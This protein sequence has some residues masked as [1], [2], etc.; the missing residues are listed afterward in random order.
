[1]NW[2]R[3]LI[4]KSSRKLSQETALPQ[5][6][7]SGA[8]A[9][10]VPR[11]RFV[12]SSGQAVEE[13]AKSCVG[14]DGV[15]RPVLEAP[16]DD[17][18]PEAWV[19]A[20]CRTSDKS[21]A[22]AWTARVGDESALADIAAR[23]RF[24]EVRLAA[25]SRIA[26]PV[27]FARVAEASRDKDKRIFRLCSERLR[28]QRDAAQRRERCERLGQELRE[29]LATVPIPGTRLPPLEQEF[30]ALE[31]VSASSEILVWLDQVRERFRAETRA[32]HQMQADLAAG[33][34]ILAEIQST[35]APSPKKREAWADRLREME[36]IAAE[37]PAWLLAHQDGRR[38]R[39]VLGQVES[40]LAH[41]AADSRDASAEQLSSGGILDVAGVHTVLEIA[42]VMPASPIDGEVMAGQDEL[43]RARSE[44][45]GTASPSRRGREQVNAKQADSPSDSEP[46]AQLSLQKDE[47]ATL[48]TLLTEVEGFL[49]KGQLA[50][51]E[52]VDKR[53]EQVAQGA[54]P[55]GAVGR[56]WSRARGQIARLRSWA[57]WGTDQ[58]REHLIAD[59]ESLLRGEP[60]LDER[61]RLVPAWRR[62]WKRLNTH[63][64]ATKEQWERFN[65]ALTL[66]YEPVAAKRAEEIA[67][68]KL[69]RARKVQLCD[70]LEPWLAQVD[71][72][73]LDCR[74]IEAKRQDVVARWRALPLAGF[75]D[76]RGLRKRFDGL[77]RQLDV[78]LKVARDAE[79]ARR[80]DLIAAARALGQ[81][82]D[83]AWAINETKSLQ[84]R[85][86]SEATSIRLPRAGE[87]STWER[88]RAACD[89]VFARRDAARAETAAHRDQRARERE[90]EIDQ[91]VATVEGADESTLLR[92]MKQFRG[93]LGDGRPSHRP[94]LLDGR[95]QEAI[96]AAE[97]RLATLRLERAKARFE[98]MAKKAALAE[99]M[100]LAAAD[101]TLTEEL[102]I[103]IRESWNVLPGLPARLEREM[104]QRLSAAPSATS[105]TLLAGLAARA[106]LLLDLE[107]GLGLPSPSFQAEARRERQLTQLKKHFASAAVEVWNPETQVVSWYA[108]PA[109]PDPDQQARLALVVE[110][111]ARNS[112]DWAG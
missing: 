56:R 71:W 89:A 64:P 63:G 88:F 10:D 83:L 18:S 2:L 47:Q 62:E 39:Q 24:G 15:K 73:N 29:L 74:I 84:A 41:R 103:R 4:G 75:R 23:A 109:A 52:A 80:E 112:G 8:P 28:T 58:V 110:H 22:M 104:L 36:S 6:T 91:F 11:F 54:M 40:A 34:A 1:M 50:D 94:D 59:A 35:D 48:R 81:T 68:Q 77:V 42:S 107:I 31:D 3:T 79:L 93:A 37:C 111:L 65:A 20:V 102:S 96:L 5:R 19:Q 51:A 12:F 46:R 30:R 53:I 85:W 32:L 67:E 105:E 17:D 55:H 60:D 76:E 13:R 25:A 99:Q 78:K 44:D 33:E 106:V 21:L 98:T 101:A 45:R 90:I 7:A 92:A 82:A 43:G 69:A 108:T 26:D 14:I 70:E 87:Q 72:D 57:R 100:E 66:A 9:R 27:L 97:A 95:V 61:A 38:L 86:R 16:A 49:E